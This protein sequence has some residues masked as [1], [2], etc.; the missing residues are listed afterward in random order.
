MNHKRS[1]E[2]FL[3]YHNIA[4]NY[5]PNNLINAF[6]SEIIP[7]KLAPVD[8]SK[9][10]EEFNAKGELEGYFWRYGETLNLE[11]N[12]DGEITIE[13]DA[14]VTDIHKQVPSKQ[15]VG[16]IGQ[17]C[18]NLVDLR[19]WTCTVLMNGN[20]IWTEDE[21][22]T[23]P[24]EGDIKKI[25]LSADSYLK[26]KNIEIVIYNFRMEPIYRETHLAMPKV[27]FPITPEL[28]KKLV[29]GTYYCSLCVFNEEVSFKIFDAN[30]F[31]LIPGD[32]AI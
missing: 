15:T 2:M 13:S 31:V 14:I 10:Y 16:Y 23:Y 22:F 17:K 19:S 11:F 3:N 21:S 12:I 28:S 5:K 25:Y 4:D 20:Y 27:I 18:Y 24:T 8:A 6:P 30:I 9:P 1:H 32:V 29:K 26:N 7:S